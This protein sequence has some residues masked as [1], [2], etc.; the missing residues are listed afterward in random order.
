MFPTT[1]SEKKLLK[2]VNE[3]R[4][5][6]TREMLIDA[7]R[8]DLFL[9]LCLS[10]VVAA[11]GNGQPAFFLENGVLMRWWIPYSSE[12]NVVEQIV[13]PKDYRWQVLSLAHDSSLVVH[14]GVKKTYNRRIVNIQ[15]S[16]TLPLLLS[17]SI[18]TPQVNQAQRAGL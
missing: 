4:L 16:E 12:I 1:E 17:L 18:D 5:N 6:V 13:V 8:N 11:E 2:S 14:L 15:R 9:T 7:Q 3:L 10:S